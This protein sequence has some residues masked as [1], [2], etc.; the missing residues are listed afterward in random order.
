MPPR[1]AHSPASRTIHRRLRRRG[2]RYDRHRHFDHGPGDST[3]VVGSS[4]RPRTR[5]TPARRG[6]RQ[7]QHGSELSG[8]AGCRRSGVYGSGP[9]RPRRHRADFRATARATRAG[10]RRRFRRR[11]RNRVRLRRPA[12]D[13]AVRH[14][15]RVDACAPWRRRR[16][17]CRQPSRRCRRRAEPSLRHRSGRRV[18]AR[19]RSP[20]RPWDSL[21][22]LQCSTAAGPVTGPDWAV[23]PA[24][25]GLTSLDGAG[26]RGARR[27]VA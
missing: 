25:A 26:G 23:S 12:C 16:P 13:V 10:R 14:A 11:A 15:T 9:V 2:R 7:R 6:H 20:S 17:S 4:N 24:S 21:L 27:N 5:P 19:C 8:P 18:A 1:R 3:Y 22:T